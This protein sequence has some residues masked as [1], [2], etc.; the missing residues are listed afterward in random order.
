MSSRAL[1]RRMRLASSALLG[2]S[3]AEAHCSIA[4]IQTNTARCNGPALLNRRFAIRSSVRQTTSFRKKQKA[5]QIRVFLVYYA[6]RGPS[7]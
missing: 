6:A 7:L 4:I 3:L 1:R 5:A 2:L